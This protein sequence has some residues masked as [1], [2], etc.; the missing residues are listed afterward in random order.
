MFVCVCVCGDTDTCTH[1]KADSSL[2]HSVNRYLLKSQVLM[3]NPAYTDTA[4]SP[5]SPPPSYLEASA[6]PPHS[7]QLPSTPPPAY[8]PGSYPPSYNEIDTAQSQA[9]HHGNHTNPYPVLS[10]PGNVVIHQEVMIATQTMSQP[11]AVIQVQPVALADSPTVTVCPHCHHQVT[12]N[13]THKSG[14]AAWST[15]LL[16]TLLGL[17]CGFCLIP[18]LIDGCKDVHH[19]CPHCNRHIGIFIRK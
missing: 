4:V 8:T 1:T 3:D 7:A 14:M 2:T 17:I 13:T 10:I 9:H 15:C 5:A 11:V 12:T 18:F 16:L 6:Y 19:S